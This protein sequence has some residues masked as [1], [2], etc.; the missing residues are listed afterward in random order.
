MEEEN[1][2]K[3]K[4]IIKVLLGNKWLYLIMVGLFFVAGVVGLS[5]YSQ[6][7]SEYVAF[8]DYDI[9]GFSTNVDESG[10]IYASYL[11]GEKFDPRSLIT[12]EKIK[13][14]F[15]NNE[16]L[17]NL[18]AEKLYKN[19]VIKSFGYKIKYAKNNHK[20]DSNDADYIES[21][22]GYE[23][24]L[25]A[26]FLNKSQAKVLSET[27]ANE[28]LRISNI[29]IDKIQYDMYLTYCDNTNNYPEK[30][31]NLKNG[32]D[33]LKELSDS[34]SKTYGDVILEEGKYGGTDEKYFLESN[35]FSNWQKR[36]NY[37]FDSYYV[38][39]LSSELEV[40]GYVSKDSILYITSLKTNIANL[41]RERDVNSGILHDLE[42]QRDQLIGK[43]GTDVTIESVEIGEFNNEIIALTKLIAEEQERIDIYTLQLQK[44]EASTLSQ[45]YID[46]LNV[47]DSKVTDIRND[48]EFYTNQYEAIA[49]Q[50]MKNNS[51]VY[52]DCPDVVALQ[53]NVQILVIGAAS[54]GIALFAPILVNLAIAVFNAADGKHIIFKKKD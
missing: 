20:I 39:S 40:N 34:L 48:L 51:S 26:K 14:Y 33:Y 42:T 43:I 53:G 54:I 22:R 5:I 31:S 50:V 29:K 4:D 32:I 38:E 28:V 8:Y 16:E 12:Q 30:V 10:N 36:L 35:S 23:L 13:E 47:F 49:K 19:N 25:N 6:Q 7:K 1:G 9:A 37:T 3:L 44:A 45:E 41:E 2:L 24:V 11:D 46:S 18:D 17:K 15:S 52:F 27:I 21:N